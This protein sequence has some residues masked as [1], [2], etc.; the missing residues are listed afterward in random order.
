MHKG[1][2]T[3]FAGIDHEEWM[4]TPIENKGKQVKVGS[5]ET[6]KKI[7]TQINSVFI[8]N[9]FKV[10]QQSNVVVS[11]HLLESKKYKQ[12]ELRRYVQENHA[13]LMGMVETRVK[14]PKAAAIAQQILPGYSLIYNYTY[15]PNGII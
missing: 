5:L 2:N 8:R 15:A 11:E 12:K 13:K 4:F 1:E 10:L 14:Y 7:Y 3:G 9:I 6:G